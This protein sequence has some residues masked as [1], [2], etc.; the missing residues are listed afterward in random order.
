MTVGV[1][2]APKMRVMNFERLEKK[3]VRGV[4]SVMSRR[5]E[6][7]SASAVFSG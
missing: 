5:S 4:S 6:G 2:G 3:K 1:A 7:A